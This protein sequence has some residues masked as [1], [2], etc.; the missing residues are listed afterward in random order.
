M[1]Q[2]NPFTD[3]MT[4]LGLDEDQA[5]AYL[6]VPVFTFRKWVAGNRKPSAAVNRLL[7][8]LGTIEA[9]AP[10]IHAAFLP[11]H[12]E[13]VPGKSNAHESKVPTDSVMSKNPVSRSQ[14]Q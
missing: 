2:Q 8:V 13:K 5:S 3:L 14:P 9:L 4:R 6:G 1:T 11:A 12:V 10:A 7:H